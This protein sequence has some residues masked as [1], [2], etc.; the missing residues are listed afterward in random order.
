MKRDEIVSA[1]KMLSD[2]LCSHGIKADLFLVGGA[3]LCVAYRAREQTR[4]VDAVFTHTGEV[5]K[6]ALVVAQ[7][8]NLPDNWLND[9]VKGFLEKADPSPV[10]VMDEAGL[11][12]MAASPRYLLAL[13]LLASREE[14]EWD[15]RFLCDYLG[16]RTAAEALQIA[17]DVYP[18]SRLLPKTRFFVEE[19]LGA[20]DSGEVNRKT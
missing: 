6:A 8:M 7:T 12:V 14:D 9:A 17:L 18:E 19:I 16:I 13:K 5:R 4:D 3:A 15:I 11:R 10:A 2:M 1:L 20:T